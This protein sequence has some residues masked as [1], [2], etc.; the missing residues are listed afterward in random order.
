MNKKE[1]LENLEKY[2]FYHRIRLNDE[3]I[4][5]GINRAQI[6]KNL[7]LINEMD[8]KNKKVLDIGCR[9][10][11]YC[12]EAEKLGAKEVIGIDNDISEAAINFLIPYFKSKVK[13]HEKNLF[14]LTTEDFGKF[15][16]IFF[17]GTLY[18]LRYPFF[19]LKIVS[20]LL[21]EG[22]QLLIETSILLEDK[23]RAMLFCPTGKEG[24]YGSTSCTFFNSK[25]LIDT[26]NSIGIKVISHKLSLK[27]NFLKN[28]LKSILRI[29]KIKTLFG[30]NLT[31]VCRG[32]F[33]CKKDSSII[34]K[35]DHE[36][37]NFSHKRHS[38]FQKESKSYK[39]F[40]KGRNEKK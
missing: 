15:D 1:I 19:A 20:D 2:N 16:V 40:F 26:L 28:F 8:I 30:K 14:D 7:K 31:S 24:P 13:M 11:I 9:D 23:D 22:G 29:F 3:I 32:L 34:N 38:I 6:S 12:F 25:G 35:N 21:N 10:S 27:E 33:Y 4:T 18:H 17:P 37:W 5:P 36:Y 39:D